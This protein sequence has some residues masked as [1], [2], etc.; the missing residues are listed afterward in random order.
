MT[1][2][3]E[4][5][6]IE[7]L[8]YAGAILAILVGCSTE[9]PFTKRVPVVIDAPA[10]PATVTVTVGQPASTTRAAAPRRTVRATVTRRRVVDGSGGR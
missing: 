6:R 5:Q 10:D 2:V 9:E 1:R 3:V 8:L 7:P 4:L